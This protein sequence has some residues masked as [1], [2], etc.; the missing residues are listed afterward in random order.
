[1]GQ[2]GTGDGVGET[3]LY[4]CRAASAA[5]H[6]AHLAAFSPS[7]SSDEV[8]LYGGEVASGGLV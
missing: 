2:G 4:W 7:S 5:A 6:L 3:G 1:M 8:G